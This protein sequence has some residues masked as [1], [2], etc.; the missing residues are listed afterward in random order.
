MRAE[1]APP[2]QGRKIAH[3]HRQCYLV[4]HALFFLIAI[5]NNIG[6]AGLRH[7]R[8]SAHTSCTYEHNFRQF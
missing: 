6:A 5:Q 1:A 2:A 8:D 3:M 7:L 4:T